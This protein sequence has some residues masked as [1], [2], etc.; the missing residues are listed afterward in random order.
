MIERCVIDNYGGMCPGAM[1]YAEQT[2]LGLLD[3]LDAYFC[4][5]KD[6]VARQIAMHMNPKTEYFPGITFPFDDV[7][8]MCWKQT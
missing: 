4:I 5:E 7:E 1:W 8:R 2:R 6:P 3:K